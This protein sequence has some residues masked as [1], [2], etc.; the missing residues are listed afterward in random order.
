MFS[1]LKEAI[2]YV[3]SRGIE[4]FLSVGKFSI[5]NHKV[6]GITVV[7]LTYIANHWTFT[8]D[9]Q[10]TAQNLLITAMFA[11]L[12]DTPKRSIG[13]QIQLILPT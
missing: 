3:K 10:K 13:S 1:K 9:L 7:T 2:A 8:E 5:N 11:S 4:V 12:K 6:V